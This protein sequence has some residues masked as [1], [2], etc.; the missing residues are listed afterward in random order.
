MRRTTMEELVIDISPEGKVEAL[1]MD[2]F[3]LGFLGKK[4]ISRASEIHFNEES[5]LWD[6]ILPGR[7]KP[8]NEAVMGFVS[9]DVARSFEVE[10]LQAARKNRVS[11]ESTPG[12]ILAIRIRNDF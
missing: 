10:W 7:D 1:H 11:P 8:E 12:H 3:D 9:Y 5:Q 6:I 4:K 2:E